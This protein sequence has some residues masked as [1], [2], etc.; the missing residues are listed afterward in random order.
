[1]F[2]GLLTNLFI[3]TQRAIRATRP[4]Q[5]G[6]RSNRNLLRFKY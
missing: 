2:I 6:P 5:T 4:S 3:N 1:M